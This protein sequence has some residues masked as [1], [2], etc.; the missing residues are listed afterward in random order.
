VQSFGL[1]PFYSLHPSAFALQAFV[2]PPFY[3]LPQSF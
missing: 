3:L 1:L 2:L